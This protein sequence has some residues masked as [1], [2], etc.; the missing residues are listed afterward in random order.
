MCLFLLNIAATIVHGLPTGREF[1]QEGN[2]QSHEYA[3]I[4]DDGHNEWQA[5]G[6][7]HHF[8]QHE[9]HSPIQYDHLDPWGSPMFDG[10]L[11]NLM[12]REAET[13]ETI[14]QDNTSV[15]GQSHFNIPP[16]LYEDTGLAQEYDNWNVHTNDNEQ[17]QTFEEEDNTA[18][19][20]Y[21]YLQS[22]Q[23]DTLEDSTVKSSTKAPRD[24]TMERHRIAERKSLV[25]QQFQQLGWTPDMEPKV[26]AIHASLMKPRG[27]PRVITDTIH[28][29]LLDN[30]VSTEYLQAFARSRRT[31]RQRRY[32]MAS[33][34][35]ALEGM[36][37]E[38]VAASSRVA[39]GL[40]DAGIDLVNAPIHDLEMATRALNTF[41][42][43]DK[44]YDNT[45]R[46]YLCRTRGV[47][48]A[49]AFNF[50]RKRYREEQRKLRRSR[51]AA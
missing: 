35:P 14:Q 2:F 9:A 41:D 39:A 17:S 3:S 20:S 42:L 12:P 15:Y 23:E 6:A 11:L 43:N 8:T 50:F 7:S 47:P 13:S 36:T 30:H 18:T 37:R 44:T 38:Q 21:D 46:D 22:E 27:N 16:L 5:Q 28:E 48:E 1:H 51:R 29:A 49:F 4:D 25:Y 24:R 33:N 34:I 32:V 40:Q 31:Q 45:L 19:M 10:N 26:L